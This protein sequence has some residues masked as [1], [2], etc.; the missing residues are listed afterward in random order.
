MRKRTH[1]RWPIIGLLR[2]ALCL[3]VVLPLAGTV[4][5]TRA[6]AASPVSFEAWREAFWP[7]ARAFGISRV[8]FD[9]AFAG[10]TPDLSLPDLKLP[11]GGKKTVK[12]QAEFT[13][14]PQAYVSGT[15]IARLARQ[16]RELA[17]RHRDALARIH[18][19]LGVAPHVLLALWGRETA[20][21][22]YRLPHDAIRALA[23]QAYTGRRADMFRE[24]L[25]YALRMLEAG[26][27]ERANFRS[28]WAGAVGLTQ[29]MPSE[30]FSLAYDL[31]GDGRKDI[32][33]PADAL[34]SAASQLRKKGWEVGKTWG[35]EVTLPS[36]VTCA[37]DGPGGARTIAGWAAL[38]VKRTAGRQFPKSY[39]ND[40]AFLFTPGG[41]NGPA[42]LVLENFMVFKR[43]N[44]SD[45]Y[46]LFV[47]HLADRIAGGGD[48][49]SGWGRIRQLPARRIAA[50]Q[51][52]LKRGGFSIS[53]VD[54]KI[55]ANT[56]SQ[57]GQYQVRYGLEV[58]CWPSEALLDEMTRRY[59][60]ASPS[61]PV[62]GAD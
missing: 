16:G 33:S 48:F 25:L 53:K 11:G 54:G 21:G 22:N 34:A 56:R 20:F 17:A 19:E 1:S 61:A 23:T 24:E 36:R 57:I 49:V 27:I 44:P 38:G 13:R 58:D 39:A 43:Y 32:W 60:P 14:P 2:V 41:G 50:I 4:G 46:A 18:R 28:S 59:G 47:G 37:M 8:T 40:E 35:F 52:H 62:T 9:K 5:A 10:I 26:V 3:A 31:D 51:A 55:G 42:F 45:L 30:Y 12:G 29:F 15:Y 6:I 7:E